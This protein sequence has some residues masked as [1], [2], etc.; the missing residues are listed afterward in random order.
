MTTTHPGR[1]SE[2]ATFDR[3][4]VDLGFGLLTWGLR[5][6]ALRRA[7]VHDAPRSRT[8]DSGPAVRPPSER[9]ATDRMIHTHFGIR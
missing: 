5:R 9:A 8:G 1:S 2:F 4:L 3:I 6:A 7:R